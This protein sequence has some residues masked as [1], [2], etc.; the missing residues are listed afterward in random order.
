M[1]YYID[2]ATGPSTFG[3]WCESCLKP[4]V[5]ETPVYGLGETGPYQ[6]GVDRD[7]RDCAGG[8]HG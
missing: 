7:C 8:S 2:I 4:S 5:V 1:T 3:H 6:M